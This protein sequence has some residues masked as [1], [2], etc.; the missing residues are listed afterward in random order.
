[1]KK[2]G[3]IA[4][5][6]LLIFG[7]CVKE[8]READKKNL[9]YPVQIEF[10]NG[11]KTVMNPNYSRD[12]RTNYKIGNVITLGDERAPE[13]GKLFFP[14]DIQ[15][16]SQDQIY[17]LD[18]EDV[19]IKMYDKNG[20]WLRNYGRRGQGPGEFTTI[21][22][23]AVSHDGK[24]FILDTQQHRVLVLKPD[25]TSDSSF[26][27]KGSC[28][29]LKV[30]ERGQVY[31]QQNIS[32]IRK[33]DYGSYDMEMI[34]KRTDANGKNL[35]EYGRFPYLRFVWGPKKTERGTRIIPHQSREAHTTVWIVGKDNRLYVGNSGNYLIT[36]LNRKGK[37]LF[38]FGREFT[39]I[40]H[41]LYNPDLAHPKYYPAF[42]SRYFFI[43]DDEN[44]W[45]KQYN[46][47]KIDHIYDV[48]SKDGIF[49][50]QAVVPERIFRYQNGKVY[51][52]IESESGEYMAKC[53]KLLDVKSSE[54]LS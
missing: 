13:E 49:V 11:I 27:V 41:P 1:M 10:I 9:G 21:S 51:T 33:G 46:E 18:A 14:Y 36:V 32:F 12:G 20:I 29:R 54:S 8:K 22:D 28:L 5:I 35:F 39:Q 4:V 38:K 48:F 17:V 43:D 3:I 52:I 26:M 15:V 23:F 2:S 30:D 47:N 24:I 37:P 50:H 40:K 44:L 42:Y 34:L 16:D 7:Q 31:L 25:G 19:N 6:I 45:L 53:Y